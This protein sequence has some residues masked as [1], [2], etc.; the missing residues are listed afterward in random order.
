[1]FRFERCIKASYAYM[2][3]PIPKDYEHHVSYL[4]FVS[5]NCQLMDMLAVLQDFKAILLTCC[6]YT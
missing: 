5:L 4:E 6:Y 2:T 1:M 3:A